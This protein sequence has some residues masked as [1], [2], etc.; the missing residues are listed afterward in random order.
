MPHLQVL[1]PRQQTLRPKAAACTA[2]PHAPIVSAIGD[3]RR[4]SPPVYACLAQDESGS[5]P[6]LLLPGSPR[7]SM[8][9]CRPGSCVKTGMASSYIALQQRCM[10]IRL[11]LRLSPFSPGRCLSTRCPTLLTRSGIPLV[12]ARQLVAVCL[13]RSDWPDISYC[14][15]LL[16]SQ[17][18]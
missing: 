18:I 3:C 6:D 14:A 9:P 16:H 12:P 7:G 1:S 17:Q 8:P 15:C 10:H 2:A 11:R 5:G 4:T 13:R